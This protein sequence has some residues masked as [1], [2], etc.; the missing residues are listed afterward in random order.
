MLDIK[1]TKID[2]ISVNDLVK[3]VLD[4]MKGSMVLRKRAQQ[5]F[6]EGLDQTAVCKFL[7][8]KDGDLRRVLDRQGVL[9]D[10]LLHSAL[11]VALTKEKGVYTHEST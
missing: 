8:S 7:S 6:A 3:Y 5:H 2:H 4:R 9:Y 11:V 1:I 10:P